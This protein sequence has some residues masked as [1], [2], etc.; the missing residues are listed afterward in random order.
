MIRV[1]A[2]TLI[3]IM[4]RG[5]WLW[6]L[7]PLSTIFQLYRGS[8]FYWWRKL[9]YDYPE[10]TTN[11]SHEE[12]DYHILAMHV[13]VLINIKWIPINIDFTSNLAQKR[14]F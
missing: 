12:R 3:F 10:K 7:M 4:K 2:G 13:H 14:V 9:E 5:L 1:S 8:Q 11:L 6:C